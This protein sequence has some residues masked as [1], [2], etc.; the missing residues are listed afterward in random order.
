MGNLRKR[1]RLSYLLK[2]ML[3][4][5]VAAEGGGALFSLTNMI[6]IIFLLSSFLAGR[7]NRE[8]VFN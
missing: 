4:K 8:N 6:V 3:G 7:E 2:S 1:F 5:S